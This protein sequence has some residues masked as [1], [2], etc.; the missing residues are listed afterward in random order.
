MKMNIKDMTTNDKIPFTTIESR[1]VLCRRACEYI[2]L[3]MMTV[4]LTFI[5]LVWSP[6]T[7]VNCPP[8]IVALRR[9]WNM[10]M[11]VIIMARARTCVTYLSKQFPH[12]DF[13]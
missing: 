2:R 1:R 4:T 7:M 13:D 8:L 12:F 10:D 5:V 9:L 3:L 6:P 11:V